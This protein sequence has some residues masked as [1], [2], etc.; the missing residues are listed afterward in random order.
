MGERRKGRVGEMEYWSAGVLRERRK[1]KVLSVGCWVLRNRQR[2][3][4]GEME[5]WSAG[6]LRERRTG[7]VGEMECWSLGVLRETVP[8]VCGCHQDLGGCE[9]FRNRPPLPLPSRWNRD[10]R[11]PGTTHPARGREK[12]AIPGAGGC[13]PDLGR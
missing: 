7:R 8:G 11:P 1:G 6:V 3:R 13:R 5:Y 10:L 9:S 4:V 2:G 12:C